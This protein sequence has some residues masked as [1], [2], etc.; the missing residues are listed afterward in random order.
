MS[1]VPSGGNIWKNIAIGVFTTVAAYAIINFIGLGK[2]DYT[3]KNK[4][5][6]TEKA[7]ISA[8]KYLNY[9]NEK[10][11]TIACF[12]CDED[13]MK[14]ELMRELDIYSNSLN[15]IKSDKDVDD[16][17]LSAIDRINQQ[18]TD[19]KPLYE[20]YFDSIIIL[21]NFP[22]EK[23][24]EL[25]QPMQMRFIEKLAT[26]QTK[27]TSEIINYLNDINERFHTTLKFELTKMEYDPS[28]LVG[29]WKIECA[30]D[31]TF[32]KD[33]TI[34]WTEDQ[35]NFNGKWTFADKKLHI[36]LENGQIFDFVIIQLSQKMLIYL[37]TDNN[38]LLSGCKQKTE[39]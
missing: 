6:A 14:K 26:I 5:D 31:L 21:K 18:F 11:K 23:R 37:N 10:F 17:M 38:A 28:A 33:N 1:S 2:K 24:A 30:A 27:D 22:F 13:L 9:A 39:N 20:N 34:N 16:K 7:W 29:K 19:M 12:S 36:S 8:N 32:N 25:S 15:N 35:N 4:K 3:Q